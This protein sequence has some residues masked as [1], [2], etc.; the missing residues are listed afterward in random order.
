MWVVF[1]NGSLGPIQSFKGGLSNQVPMVT[2]SLKTRPVALEYKFPL[3]QSVPQGG[4]IMSA[5]Q[6]GAIICRL[7]Y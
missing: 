5:Y 7:E 4:A 3:L 1:P 2:A 6:K